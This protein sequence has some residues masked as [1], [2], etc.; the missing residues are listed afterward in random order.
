MTDFDLKFSMYVII[1]YQVV[2]DQSNKV[3]KLSCFMGEHLQII[4]SINKAIFHIFSYA[5]CVFII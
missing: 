3:K 1:P 4:L 5:Y 2:V